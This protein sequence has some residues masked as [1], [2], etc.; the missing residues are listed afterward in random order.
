MLIMIIPDL[1]ELVIESD[2]GEVAVE[3]LGRTVLSEGQ[4]TVV[5]YFVRTRIGSDPWQGPILWLHR[6]QKMSQGWKLV[7]RFKTTQPD[8]VEKL[9]KALQ[10]WSQDYS[11]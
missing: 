9:S 1:D 3:E 2:D 8:Q 11:S 10:K 7:S 4:W 5:A 6:Y